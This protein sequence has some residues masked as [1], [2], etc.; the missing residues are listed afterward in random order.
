[1]KIG[2]VLSSAN[3]A[4][5]R[6]GK[7][8]SGEDSRRLADKITVSMLNRTPDA[9]AHTVLITWPTSG[10]TVVNNTKVYVTSSDNV[11]V[12]RLDLLVDGQFYATSS[13]A[14]AVFTWNT[15]KLEHGAH[16]LEAVAHDAAGNSTRSAAVTVYK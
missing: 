7:E 6:E 9:T 1:V 12:T 16:I 10:V 13:S 15:L 14:V 11:A 5:P 8:N 4:N 3:N 2:A